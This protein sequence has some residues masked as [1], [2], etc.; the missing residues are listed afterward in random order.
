MATL[1]NVVFND[2]ACRAAPPCYSERMRKITI[3]ALILAMALSAC[4]GCRPSLKT[5][6]TY[7]NKAYITY[8]QSDACV[9]RFKNDRCADDRECSVFYGGSY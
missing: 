6:N 5:V 2:F 8:F 4:G 9:E 3:G 1:L 7:C